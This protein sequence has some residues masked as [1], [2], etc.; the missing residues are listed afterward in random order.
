[1]SS[2]KSGMFYGADKAIFENA[3]KLRLKMTTSEAILWE[4]LSKNQLGVRLKSQH[5]ISNFIVDFYCHKAGL[6]IEVDGHIHFNE[7]K[8]AEDIKRQDDIE[9]L[10]LLIIRFTNE[11]INQEIETVVNEIKNCLSERLS[12]K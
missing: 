1:M 3:K 2:K 8:T 6:I 10:G 11:Q 12:K 9:A 5:P 7:S 4:R